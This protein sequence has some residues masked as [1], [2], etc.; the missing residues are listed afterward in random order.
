MPRKKDPPERK[1]GRPKS[2]PDGARPRIHWLTDAEND[3]VKALV[4]RLRG[5]TK[6]N[7]GDASAQSPG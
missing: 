5:R 7:T 6:S 3:A 2:R 4:K 1:V